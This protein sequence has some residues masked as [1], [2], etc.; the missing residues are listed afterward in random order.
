MK[1]Q[2]TTVLFAALH[3]LLSAQITFEKRY[4][5]DF[6]EA[7]N[8]I[9]QTSDGGYILAGRQGI[10]IG[11]GKILLIKTDSLGNLEWEKSYGSTSDD[12]GNAVSLVSDGGYIIT[13]YPKTPKPPYYGY[14]SPGFRFPPP[15]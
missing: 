7:A 3:L 15:I 11:Y 2:F 4:D 13:G 6:A 5:Y 1:K 10:W 8:D 14:K 9:Q 12:E